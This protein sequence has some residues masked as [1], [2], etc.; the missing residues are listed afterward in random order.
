MPKSAREK[1]PD[2]FGSTR[3]D[4]VVSLA[5]RRFPRET[6]VLGAPVKAAK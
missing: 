3:Q 6:P 5:L 1:Q 4:A 2:H